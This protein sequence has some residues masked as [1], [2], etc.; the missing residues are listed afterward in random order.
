[1]WVAGRYRGGMSDSHPVRDSAAT[2]HA[3]WKAKRA[4]YLFVVPLVL[5]VLGWAAG[6]YLFQP[7]LDETITPRYASF[8]ST[9]AQVLAAGLIALVLEVRVFSTSRA[10]LARRAAV[11]ALFFII[12]GEVASVTALSPA[13]PSALAYRWAFA[14]TVGAGVAFLFSLLLIAARTLA[15]DAAAAQDADLQAL[16]TAGDP[17][18]KRLLETPAAP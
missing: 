16:A 15:V 12:I 14:L 8:F 2:L 5:G 1:V 10:V 9:A 6:F 17:M 13:I 18:A 11:L 4:R 3:V 7:R